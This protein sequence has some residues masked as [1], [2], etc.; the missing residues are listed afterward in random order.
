[1]KENKFFITCLLLIFSLD[2]VAQKPAGS[3]FII[4][5]GDRTSEIMQQLMKT[6]QLNE[7]DYV[8]V[9]PMSSIEPDSAYLYFKDDIEKLCRNVIAN[10]NF[11]RENVDNKKMLDS[12][13][14]AKLIFITGGAF[15]PASQQFLERI[16]N[17]CFE[18]P[19]DLDELR[20][21]LRRRVA[22]RT[23]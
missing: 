6:A 20:S 3:L 14:N 12:L 5:G 2:V 10:L 7:N 1:M 21:A 19:C 8:V 11:T 4:G 17:L 9:L 18:K 15:S 23:Q 13:E 16:T 22:A